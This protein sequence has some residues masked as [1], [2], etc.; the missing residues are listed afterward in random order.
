M[1]LSILF[2]L[3]LCFCAATT[4]QVKTDTTIE[5]TIKVKGTIKYKVGDSTVKLFTIHPDSLSNND[6]IPLNPQ[7]YEVP[8][9][10]T[11]L[12]KSKMAGIGLYVDKDLWGIKSCSMNES[13]EKKF[14]CKG[15]NCFASLVTESTEDVALRDMEYFVLESALTNSPDAEITMKEFRMVNGIKV[16]CLGLKGSIKSLRFEGLTYIYTTENEIVQLWCYTTQKKFR[17]KLGIIERF[18]CGLVL[19]KER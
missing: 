7:N 9:A 15:E 16:L 3:S 10:A 2:L 19:L 5:I 13:C 8:F 17:K 12:Y 6:S 4:A 11:Y 18:L 14:L 1:K